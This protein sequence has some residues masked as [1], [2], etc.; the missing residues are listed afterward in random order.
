MD[1]VIPRSGTPGA[2]G[3]EAERGVQQM[4]D[5]PFTWTGVLSN[6]K[7]VLFGRLAQLATGISE[8]RRRSNGTCN[9]MS[10]NGGDFVFSFT[11]CKLSI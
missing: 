3:L 2:P 9:D 8:R 10:D 1:I 6:W 7:T 5:T 11:Y 4:I